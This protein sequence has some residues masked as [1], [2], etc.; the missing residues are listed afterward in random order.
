MVI[1]ITLC[2]NCMIYQSKNLLFSALLNWQWVIYRK[3]QPICDTCHIWFTWWR[4]NSSQQYSNYHP[5]LYRIVC[6][7]FLSGQLLLSSSTA[8]CFHDSTRILERWKM[9]CRNPVHVT[10]SIQT[11]ESSAEIN[12]FLLVF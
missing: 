7:I 4:R 1:S 5:W 12:R 8:S 11:F 9:D 2:S 3:S 10:L 6:L